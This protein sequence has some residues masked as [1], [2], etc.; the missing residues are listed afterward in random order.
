MAR[1]L[2]HYA[3]GHL[4]RADKL[5]KAPDWIAERLARPDSLIVPVW[6]NHNQIAGFGARPAAP[7][8]VLYTRDRAEVLMAQAS[9]VVFLGLEVDRAVFAADFSTSETPHAITLARE[10]SF[11]D[12]RQVGALLE[13]Q[14]AALMAYARGMVYWHRHHRF[15]GACGHATESRLGGHMRQCTNPACGRETFPRTDPAVIMLVEHRPPG[16]APARCLLGRQS[17]WPPGSYSTLASFV[18]PGESLEE[19]VAREVFEETGV[20]LAQ[21]VYQASQPWPFP[22]SIMVGYRA[23][24][25]TTEVGV[26][27]DELEDARWFTAEEVCRA[28]EWGDDGASLKLPRKDSISRFL[29]DSWAGEQTNA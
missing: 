24:A 25:A 29:I 26:D 19:A 1:I 21:V 10:E 5:R 14:E 7:R 15:C 23:L 27:G 22:A 8:A 4:D 6:R 18:E 9:E 13:A 11:V 3:G 16:G 20:R 2:L 17:S 12:V 28:A